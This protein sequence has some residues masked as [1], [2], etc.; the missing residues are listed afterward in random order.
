MQLINNAVEEIEWEEDRRCANIKVVFKMTSRLNSKHFN[1][2]IYDVPV[3]INIF[4]IMLEIPESTRLLLLPPHELF[5][6]SLGTVAQ[7]LMTSENLLSKV[8]VNFP[9]RRTLLKDLRTLN[10]SG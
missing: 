7:Y 3:V 10:L 8:T 4:K 2:Q 6:P 9:E 5:C 1:V